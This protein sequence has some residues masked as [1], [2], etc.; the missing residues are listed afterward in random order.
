MKTLSIG[1]ETTFPV[2]AWKEWNPSG[3]QVVAGGGYA[4]RVAE[5]TEE[6]KDAAVTSS[7]SKGWGRPASWIGSLFRRRARAR[8]LPMYTLVGS[9]DEDDTTFFLIGD[10]TLLQASKEGQ[11]QAFANDWPGRYSNNKGRLTLRVRRVT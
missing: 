5:I 4:I 9:I 3:I 6:W 10:A 11:L 1:E 7:P 8:D 2:D